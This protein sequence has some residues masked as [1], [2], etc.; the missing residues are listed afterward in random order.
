MRVFRGIPTNH[1]PVALTIGNFD[2]VHVGHQAMLLRLI[3]SARERNLP[4]SVMTFEPHPR[5]LFAQTKEQVPTR[6]TSLR[7][8]LEL[9]KSVG[10]DEVYVCHFNH[11]F[12]KTTA[13]QFIVDLLHKRLSVQWLLVGDDFSFG[14]HRQGNYEF[15]SHYANDL[16]FELHSMPSVEVDGQRISS[17]LIRD[18]LAAG[19]FALAEKYLNRPYTMSG[20]VMHGDKIGRTIGFPTANINIKHKR[21]PITGIFAV[22]LWLSDSTSYLGAA[23]LGTRPTITDSGIYRLEVHVLDFDGN[24]YDQQVKVEFFH[25]LRDE[26]RYLDMET[27]IKQITLDVENIRQFFAEHTEITSQQNV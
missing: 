17:S 3:A 13:E 2:G 11:T 27:L 10:V 8:K 7:E 16:G 5:E 26:E 14:A 18:V 25:K 6:L 23:S 20:K 9:L 15:L 24:L 19:N 1:R 22:K 4:A 12:A 21:P